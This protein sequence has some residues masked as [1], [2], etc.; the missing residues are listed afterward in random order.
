MV[1]VFIFGMKFCTS[2]PAITSSLAK[3]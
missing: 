1:E 3:V 2:F